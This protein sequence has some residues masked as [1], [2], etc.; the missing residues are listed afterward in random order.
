MKLIQLCTGMLIFELCN[1]KLA[2]TQSHELITLRDM[3]ADN[4]IVGE[5]T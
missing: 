3:H 4:A 2:D 1:V 5:G